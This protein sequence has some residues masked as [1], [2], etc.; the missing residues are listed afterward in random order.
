[1]SERP[2]R[3]HFASQPSPPGIEHCEGNGCRLRGRRIGIGDSGCGLRKGR[4]F[5]T[6]SRLRIYAGLADRDSRL[7][8]PIQKTG[9]DWSRARRLC[10]A[11]GNRRR[12][13]G[14]SLIMQ[15]S[16][17]GRTSTRVDTAPWPKG[18]DSA[19]PE[20]PKNFV[21]QVTDCEP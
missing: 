16:S 18:I 14:R 1:M 15:R 9:L 6:G 17:G 3:D 10:P 4:E 2:E 5:G 11:F 12:E 13:I 20:S 7:V 8:E 19:A 21:V